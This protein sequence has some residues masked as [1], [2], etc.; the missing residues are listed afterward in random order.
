V[1]PFVAWDGRAHRRRL[2][3]HPKRFAVTQ[4]HWIRVADGMLIEHWAS[5]DDLGM[6]K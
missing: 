2:P 5:R 4:S 1:R 3:A 6:A